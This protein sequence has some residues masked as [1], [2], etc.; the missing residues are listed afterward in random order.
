MW[1]S[2]SPD[3]RAILV[4]SELKRN[5]QQQQQQQQQQQ[6]DR[7]DSCT[8]P[9]TMSPSSSLT[10]SSDQ[11]SSLGGSTNDDG[12]DDVEQVA[13]KHEK[14]PVSGADVALTPL[15]R[16]PEN[17]FAFT[18]T[19]A[20]ERTDVV[21]TPAATITTTTKVVS[22]S[23]GWRN[24]FSL[25]ISYDVNMVAHGTLFDPINSQLLDATGV[26]PE[27]YN[28]RFAVVDSAIDALY[29]DRI[30]GYFRAK[31]VELTTCVIDGGEADKRPKVSRYFSVAFLTKAFC[32]AIT[33]SSLHIILWLGFNL[34]CFPSSNLFFVES[35]ARRPSAFVRA[36]AV[37][38]ILDE[39]CAYKLR[40]REP[41][42]AIGGGCVLDIAGMAACLYRRGVPFVRVPTTL[43]AI[44]DASV[45]V[46]NGVDYCCQ[47][48]EESYKNR[49]GSFYAPSA[50]L[51]D[52]GFI[53]SQD[54][55]NISNGLGE[56]L[57]LALVR[58]S[59]LFE[60][61]E[62]HGRVLVETRFEDESLKQSGVSGRIID[63]SIQIMLEEL[64]PNL[65]ESKL[66]RC[67]DYGELISFHFIHSWGIHISMD[68]SLFLT[69]R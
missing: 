24:I 31:G 60:L 5:M 41:F 29:G 10:V 69:P 48:T 42:L 62:A 40:R 52:P 4:A 64:G 54:A 18:K 27:G 8:A 12:D 46:K 67:V 14:C 59:D 15:E 13:R 20:T 50:C 30:R 19:H 34:M 63:L 43:L 33:S 68:C 65:W 53:S 47:K 32:I 2:L 58:S 6:F 45:G 35:I 36:Q 1:E 61:L 44:V 39:L 26:H 56:V 66:D 3:V 9:T 22:T 25:P 21:K 17:V 51:L 16:A 55:R 28:T 38:T 7:S 11:T 37:D 57:K 49:I 23:R